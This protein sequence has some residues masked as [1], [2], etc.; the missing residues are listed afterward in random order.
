MKKHAFTALCL[1][2]GAGLAAQAKE[3]IFVAA[4][5]TRALQILPAP[6]SAQ[7]QQTQAELAELHRLENSRTAAQAAQALADDQEESLFI[8]KAQLGN[9]FTAQALPVTAALSDR[10]RNDVGIATAAAK[11]GFARVR[12]YNLDHSLH[13]VCPTK[14]KDDSYPSGHATNGYAM[15]LTLIDLLPEQRDAILARADAYAANRMV[16]GVHYRSDTEAS[17]LVAYSLHAVMWNKPQYQQ[18]LA[19]ARGELQAWQDTQPK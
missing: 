12:P 16:C 5:E 13:P 4:Q 3:P 7:S 1:C 8:F 18:E 6:T 15:A 17:R 11:A 14:T 19:A 10:V 2:I 9:G